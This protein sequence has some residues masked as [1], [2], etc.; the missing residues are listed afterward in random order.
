MYIVERDRLGI[1]AV[2][3]AALFPIFPF[4]TFQMKRKENEREEEEHEKNVTHS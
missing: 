3:D 1:K 2:R 4:L